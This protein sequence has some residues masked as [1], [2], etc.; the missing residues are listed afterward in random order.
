MSSTFV[1]THEG[2]CGVQLKHAR[3]KPNVQ[4]VDERHVLLL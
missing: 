4:L 2:G 3:A 1:A